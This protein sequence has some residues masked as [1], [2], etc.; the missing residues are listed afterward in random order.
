MLKYTEDIVFSDLESRADSTYKAG[1]I[2][3]G[4]DTHSFLSYPFCLIS[5]SCLCS[6]FSHMRMH[7][8]VFI[9]LNKSSPAPL[10]TMFVAWP[11]S[12][13]HWT[14]RVPLKPRFPLYVCL[15]AQSGLALCNPLTVAHQAPQFMEFFQARILEWVAISYSQGFS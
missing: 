8:I 13:P 15:L 11:P 12:Q 7:V 2:L 5:C 14:Q 4:W 1:E 10:Q 3:W 6:S 9:F